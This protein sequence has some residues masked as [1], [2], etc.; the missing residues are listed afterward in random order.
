MDTG[1]FYSLSLK[2]RLGL[3]DKGRH[4]GSHSRQCWSYLVPDGCLPLWSSSMSSCSESGKWEGDDENYG[5]DWFHNVSAGYLGQYLL[6]GT[7]G[8]LIHEIKALASSSFISFS[9]SVMYSPCSA[10]LLQ[11]QPTVF[12]SHTT[13]VAASSHHPASS[14]FFTLLQQLPPAPTQR[15]G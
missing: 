7:N 1:A 5:G 15:T 8:G 2:K 11:H 4:W 9:V 12:S 13:P 10:V 6:V 14:V 3:R